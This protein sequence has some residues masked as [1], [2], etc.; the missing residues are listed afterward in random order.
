MSGNDPYLR[1][2]TVNVFV[3]DLER[4]LRFY[5]DQLGFGLVSDSSRQSPSRWIAVS[6]PDGTAILTLAAPPKNR[7]SSAAPA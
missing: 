7:N 6:P 3:R 4:S 2:L 5:R 1:I